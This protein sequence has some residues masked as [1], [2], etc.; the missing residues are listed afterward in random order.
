MVGFGEA[1]KRAFAGA[2]T[3]SG[4]ST[5]AE[6]WWWFLFVWLLSLIPYV[7][8]F[9][10]MDWTSNGDGSVSG[11]GGGVSALWLI[12]GVIVTLALLLPSI[13][14][15][16]RR[17]H[18]TSRSGWW[19]WIVLIPCGIGAIWYLVLML[20]PSAQGQNQYG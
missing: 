18:D 16:V 2:T 1:I 5:R 8:I 10:S 9:A 7:G 20:L 3:W 4:R 17:L 19:Y 13:A 12:I 6:Y 11:S 15:S 14:V